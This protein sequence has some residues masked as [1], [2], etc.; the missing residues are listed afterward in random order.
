MNI[1]KIPKIIFIIGDMNEHAG[2]VLEFFYERDLR[3]IYGPEDNEGSR[4]IIGFIESKFVEDISEAFSN[5]D[6]LKSNDK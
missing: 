4:E 6:E 1:I 3:P 5:Y 2:D